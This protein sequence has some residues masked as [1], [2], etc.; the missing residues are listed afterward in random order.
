MIGS[1]GPTTAAR[2][3]DYLPELMARGASLVTVAKGGRAASVVAACRG[4][5]ASIWARSASAAWLA[6]EH[7]VESEVIDYAD[8]GMEAVRRIKVKDLP[9]FVVI[10]N[11]GNDVYG[12]AA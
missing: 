9:A 12:P 11:K 7:V 1:F 6:K 2:M 10:D 3:D 5:A 8:L 4:G